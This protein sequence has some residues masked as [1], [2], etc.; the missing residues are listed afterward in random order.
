MQVSRG[1]FS[2]YLTPLPR[3]LPFTR[4]RLRRDRLYCRGSKATT[5]L[6]RRRTRKGREE[7]KGSPAYC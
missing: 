3:E 5:I 6:S 1:N 2:G 7:K 4:F